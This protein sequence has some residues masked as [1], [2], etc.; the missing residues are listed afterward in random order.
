MMVPTLTT[1]MTLMCATTTLSYGPDAKQRVDVYTPPSA[2]AQAPVALF[3]HGGVWQF[4]DRAAYRSMGEDLAK[5]GFV[6]FVASYR[7]APAHKWPAQ[8]D[9]AK[10]ALALV[11]REAAKVGGDPKRIVVIGHSAG[12]QMAAL[13]RGDP[14]VKALALFS[15]VFDLE[16]PLDEGQPDGGYASFVAPVF[17]KAQ[18]AGASPLRARTET[19]ARFDVPMLLVTSERDYRAMHAQTLAMHAMLVARKENVTLLELP[20]VDHFE[21]VASVDDTTAKKLHALVK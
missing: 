13:L 6:A 10:A 12:G 9:D 8:L 2:V 20:R 18:M 14:R 11:A 19:D 7:L 17:T 3:L 15:G 4:G 16:M 21:M 5:H 1:L